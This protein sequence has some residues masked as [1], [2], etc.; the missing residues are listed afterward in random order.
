M[1]EIAD[2]LHLEDGRVTL[3]NN[4]D[5]VNREYTF[6]LPSDTATNAR[7][8]LTFVV[9]RSNPG[10]LTYTIT[11]NGAEEISDNTQTESSRRAIQEVVSGLK[12]GTN[13]LEFE[14][15]GSG[16]LQ[17]SDIVLWFQRNI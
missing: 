12:T 4:D 17:L 9:R 1:P 7:G 10:G 6:Q 2:Y 3:P 16:T 15:S 14:V 13:T 5:G 8:V 11:L